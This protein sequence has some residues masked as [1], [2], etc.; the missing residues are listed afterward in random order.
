MPSGRK[1]ASFLVSAAI[2]ILLEIAA[3]SLLHASS[4]LQNIWLNRASHRTMAFLWGGGETIRSHFQLER[5]N[6]ELQQ[7]NASLQE[8]LRAYER[9]GVEEE[10]LARMAEREASGYRYTPATVV[11]MSRN[12]MHNYIILN[13]GSEDGIRPQ[14]GIISDRGVVG[15]VEA[16]DRHYSYGLTLMNPQMSIG[17]RVGRTDVIAP[18][19]WD[20][21]STGGA[22][23]RNIPPHYDIEPGDTVRTSG[24]SSIFPPGIPIG[25]TRE[26]RLVDGSTRQVDVRLFQ[27]FSTVRY[28]TVVENLERSEI[29][30][31]EA[32]GEGRP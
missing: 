26:T 4:T 7:E 10:E 9:L 27:D 20:G 23:V 2:F 13:K 6:Q 31:L 16:V 32:K 25:I 18:L 24:Y 5:I 12:Q 30:A 14:S 22:V 21:R 1:P 19:S 28:V 17:A 3:L 29:M 8:R 11:K 15:I